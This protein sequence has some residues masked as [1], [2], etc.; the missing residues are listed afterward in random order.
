MLKGSI[1]RFARR[2]RPDPRLCVCAAL[3]PVHP[4]P[5]PQQPTHIQPKSPL[6]AANQCA[7]NKAFKAG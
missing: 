1:Q 4:A 7:H 6:W 3:F 5:Y 2:I